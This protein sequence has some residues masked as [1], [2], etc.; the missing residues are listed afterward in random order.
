MS[1]RKKSQITLKI[2]LNALGGLCYAGVGGF[3]IMQMPKS[4]G[5]LVVFGSALL[6]IGELIW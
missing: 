4:A 3:A 6:H 1:K 2:T 5:G